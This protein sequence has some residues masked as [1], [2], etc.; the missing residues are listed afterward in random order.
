MVHRPRNQLA[1][2]I[3]LVCGAAP[4]AAP[5]QSVAVSAVRATSDHGLLGGHLDGIG[6]RIGIPIFTRV[7]LRVGAERLSGTSDRDGVTCIGVVEP[8]DEALR[9]HARLSGYFVG[10]GLRV[11]QWHRFALNLAGDV[12]RAKVHV[13]TRFQDSPSGTL[14]ANK[15]VKGVAFS[16]DGSWT[17]SVRIPVAL[18]V[19][20]T[21]GMMERRKDE[22]LIDGYSPFERDFDLTSL[23]I[24]VTWRR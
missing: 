1:A 15:A 22:T 13:D 10:V 2:V 3:L 20:V 7:S 14:T 24:G 8:C 5:A 19:G 16:V 9:D 4:A 12:R 17:P 23:R 18:E 11:G 6:G 21:R